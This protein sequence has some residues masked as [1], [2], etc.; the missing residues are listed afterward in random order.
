MVPHHIEGMMVGFLWS[1]I[2]LNADVLARLLTCGLNL[3]CMVMGE[4]K[5]APVHGAPAA[6]A[7]PD[8]AAAV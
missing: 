1:M 5:M 8:V 7:T 4:P 6:E 3:K 2:K